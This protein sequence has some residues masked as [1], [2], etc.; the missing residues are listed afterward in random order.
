MWGAQGGWLPATMAATALKYEIVPQTNHNKCKRQY[1]SSDSLGNG[2]NWR[3][4][5]QE[6]KK[7]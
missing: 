5:D 1:Y 2:E 7:N 4:R 3:V 6:G